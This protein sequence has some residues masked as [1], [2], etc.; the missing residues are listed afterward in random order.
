M[1]PFMST[2]RRHA[3][4]VVEIAMQASDT[5]E[6]S[7]V[8]TVIEASSRDLR[9][10]N[11]RPDHWYPLALSHE[12]KRGKAH[13]VR[14]AGEPIVLV[15]SASGTVFALEDRC[16]HRQIPLHDGVVDGE[17]IRCCYVCCSISRGRCSSGSPSASSRKTAGPSSANRKRMTRKALTGIARCFP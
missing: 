4:I 12:V 17:T 10:V 3:D 1:H 16:A 5:S 7:T 6:C 2:S 11:I 14:F 13:G 15:R 8:R 9:R